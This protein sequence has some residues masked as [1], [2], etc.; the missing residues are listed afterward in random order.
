[1]LERT[2]GKLLAGLLTLISL[3]PVLNKSY[4]QVTDEECADIPSE[5]CEAVNVKVARRKCGKKEESSSSH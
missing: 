1:M 5:H 2:R 3:I 4:F